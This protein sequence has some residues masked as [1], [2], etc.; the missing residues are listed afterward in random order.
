M[1][2]ILTTTTDRIEGKE[3]EKYYGIISVSLIEGVSVLKDFKASFTDV[4]GGF[5]NAYVKSI[6]KLKEVGMEKLKDKAKLLKANGIVGVKFDIEPIF[7]DKYT[8]FM[9]NISGTAVKLHSE[10]EEIYEDEKVELDIKNALIEVYDVF[11]ENYKDELNILNSKVQQLESY[12]ARE[13]VNSIDVLE[14]ILDEIKE[15]SDLIYKIEKEKLYLLKSYFENNKFE[16]IKLKLN[17]DINKD[18]AELIRLFGWIDY[19]TILQELRSNKDAKKEL[20][21]IWILDTKVENINKEEY[22]AMKEILL[23]LKEKYKKDVEMK[24]TYLGKTKG[25]VCKKCNN[26]VEQERETCNLCDT[27][28]Y[29]IRLRFTPTGKIISI[30]KRQKFLYAIISKLKEYYE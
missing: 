22:A 10:D 23:L 1:R 20:C 16:S 25:W 15:K 12:L 26:I 2:D 27:S 14:K 7:S 18:K 19:K 3:I 13:E 29:G 21:L 30:E 8:M 9:I 24:K 4:F 17:T 28:K 11:N 6:D 5:S